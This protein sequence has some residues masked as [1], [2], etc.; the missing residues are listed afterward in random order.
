MALTLDIGRQTGEFR[1]A[2]YDADVTLDNAITLSIEA[3]EAWQIYVRL[4]NQNSLSINAQKKVGSTT[5]KE[6]F[7]TATISVS[8][9]IFNANAVSSYLFQSWSRLLLESTFNST[10]YDTAA[11]NANSTTWRRER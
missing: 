3:N 1:N 4:I 10:I 8:G 5:Y 2:S 11:T 9:I 6:T 7:P